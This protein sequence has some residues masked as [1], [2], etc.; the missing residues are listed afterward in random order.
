MSRL[1][2]Q[3]VELIRRTATDLPDDVEAAILEARSREQEGSTAWNV[4][5]SL[6]RNIALA[7]QEGAPICQDTGLL[8]F[9]VSV[10]PGS[11]IRGLRRDL[12]EAARIA[13]REGL[14]RPNAVDPVTGKNSGDNVGAGLPHFSFEEHDRPEITIDLM[15]KGGGSE[16]VGAQY[17]LPDQALKAGRDIRGVEKC[18]ID[19]VFRAQGFGCAPGIIGVCIGGDRAGSYEAAKKQLLRRLDDRNPDAELDALETRMKAG[20]NELGIGPMGFGG[21]TTVLGV[22]VGK[23]H[24]HPACFFVSVAYCCWASRHRRLT[25]TDNEARVD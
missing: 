8:N 6:V 17:R 16:N 22:K 9:F 12:V 20:L 25:L 11:D 19:A 1:V 4:L 24:R 13:T 18:I 23:L 14:L 21:R 2:E 3:A 7:R 10:P 15:L 5:D